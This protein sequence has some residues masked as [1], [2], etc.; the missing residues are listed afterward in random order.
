M[1]ILYSTILLCFIDIS[2]GIPRPKR[3][4]PNGQTPNKSSNNIPH[5]HEPITPSPDTKS[6]SS[7]NQVNSTGPAASRGP[8]IANHNVGGGA[9]E[10]NSRLSGDINDIRL[11]RT[12]TDDEIEVLWDRVRNCL[13]ESPATSVR[14]APGDLQHTS[15]TS[16]PVTT[17]PKPPVKKVCR[18]LHALMCMLRYLF[19]FA[20][21][22]AVF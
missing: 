8:V 14:S 22:A 12:P 3:K 17:T 10:N 16:Q 18:V 6:R 20:T 4:P 2:S 13:L 15:P 11:D 5:I 9:G 7:K 19:I 21:A 1:F